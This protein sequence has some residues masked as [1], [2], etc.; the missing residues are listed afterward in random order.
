M[1]MSLTIQRAV[2]AEPASERYTDA[3]IG[4]VAFVA[5]VLLMLHG[6]FAV[7]RQGSGE[8]GVGAV[9]LIALTSLPLLMWR[10]APFSVFIVTAV[11]TTVLAV[12]VYPIGVPVG[13][14]VALYLLAASRDE[15]NRWLGRI[16][17][18]AI[19]LLI[20][21]AAAAAH[22]ESTFSAF[23]FLHVALLLA[24]AW[25]AGERTRLRREQIADLKR[26]A[27]RERLL[28]AAEERARIA[29]DLHDS[30]GH[31][32][33]VIAMRAGAARLRYRE[34][35]DRS[36]VALEAIEDLARRT[37]AD[38]DHLVGALR[39]RN[40]VNGVEPP[41]GLASIAN[42]VAQHTDAGLDI[43]L[44]TVSTPRP[45][46]RAVDQGAYR[47]LQEALTNASRHG[48]GTAHVEVAYRNTALELHVTNPVAERRQR[49]KGGHGLIG[50]NERVTLL[51][52]TFEAE[53]RNGTF[54]VRASLPYGA[55]CT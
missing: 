54:S 46:T 12:A 10:R 21:Y 53:R 3:A 18:A 8:L 50:M 20:G 36:L 28:A 4:I 32:I 5:S 55:S 31:A 26:D 29:R 34:D 2:R 41:A 11:A 47:I 17:V 27:Q 39:D 33:N 22:T 35:P 37:A 25:F 19:A 52:G 49:S 16:T 24:V 40:Q 48:T 44:I 23:E 1:S 42:L 14:A 43:Q 30:A 51:G 9:A 38:I 7:T 13:P 6:G 45:L 15:A